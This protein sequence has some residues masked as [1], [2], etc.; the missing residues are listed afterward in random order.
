MPTGTQSRIR[1]LFVERSDELRE[2]YREIFT[3]IGCT[4]ELVQTGAEAISAVQASRP[5]AVYSSLVLE[6]MSGLALATQLRKLDVMREVVLVALTGY[7]MDRIETR[8]REAG[9]DYYLLKPVGFFKLILPLAS[10]PRHRAA[11]AVSAVLQHA[12]EMPEAQAYAVFRRAITG[13]H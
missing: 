9:F 11:Q 8:A 1:I 7:A 10:L 5:H 4:V 13:D 2:V 6:D 12:T 3:T